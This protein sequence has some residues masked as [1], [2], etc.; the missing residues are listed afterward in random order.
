MRKPWSVAW[1]SKELDPHPTPP[2]P[3]PLLIINYRYDLNKSRGQILVV[4]KDK[5]GNKICGN[6][7][8]IKYRDLHS[9]FLHFISTSQNIIRIKIHVD[10]FMKT[11]NLQ[12][13]DLWKI[14]LWSAHINSYIE[15][16]EDRFDCIRIMKIEITCNSVINIIRND[17]FIDHS[18]EHVI[19]CLPTLK[20]LL[21]L[22]VIGIVYFTLP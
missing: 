16:L 5:R 13:F 21:Y 2:H 14:R 3:T 22:Y 15:T 19:F 18:Q 12:C 4:L 1:W 8:T 10:L 20:L 9:L 11:A 6:K 7:N 17:W